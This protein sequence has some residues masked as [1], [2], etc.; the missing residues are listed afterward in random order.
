MKILIV[1]DSKYGNNKLVAETL[2]EQL[3]EGN[4]VHL[5]RAKDAAPKKIVESVPDL[6]LFGGPLRCGMISLTI[7]G[8]VAKLS[9]MLANE[10]IK[11][12]KIGAWGTHLRDAPGT[13]EKF[14]WTAKELEWKGLMGQIPADKAMPS[15]QGI[16]VEGMEGPME[17]SWKEKV[18]QLAAGILAL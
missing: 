16:T 1:Y 2:G 11:A 9:K 4:T 3:K 7:K 8:W 10:S 15:V 13:P 5:H 6:I 14:A 17:P 12:K 18:S